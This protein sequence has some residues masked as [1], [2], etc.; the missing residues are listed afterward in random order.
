MTLTLAV[1]SLVSAIPAAVWIGGYIFKK[2][3]SDSGENGDAEN[4]DT[5]NSRSNAV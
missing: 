4:V 2:K 1:L 5:P 3:R